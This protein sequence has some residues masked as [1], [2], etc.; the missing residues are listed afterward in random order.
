MKTID[1]LQSGK[2]LLDLFEEFNIKAAL[3]AELPLAILN[4]GI[5]SPKDN[6]IARECR[7]LVIDI[8]TNELVA[9]GFNRF[10]NYGELREETDLFDFSDFHITE[11]ID[12]S[13]CLIYFFQD[14]W[15]ANTRNSFAHGKLQD[16]NLT[17]EE[18]FCRALGILDLQELDSLLDRSLTYVCEFCSPFNKVVRSYKDFEIYLLTMF[19]GENEVPYYAV[20]E[21]KN[22]F[23]LPSQFF[24][25]DIREIILFL[26]E[27]SK[28]DESFEGVVLCDKNNTRLKVKSPT[29]L[30]LHKLK[31]N[32]NIFHPSCLLPFVLSGD[33]DRL[34][35]YFPEVKERYNE[36]LHKSEDAFGRLK[37]LWEY[38]WKIEN[39]KEFALAIVRKSPFSW[40]LFDVRKRLGGKQT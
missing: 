6:S 21:Y 9:R 8:K 4:Y 38:T 15:Y 36:I 5:K 25:N 40:M 17:W 10:F 31:N 11:K 26:E 13:L 33:T 32:N 22:V 12:G 14:K 27:K 24:F 18:G 1:Y 20:R 39:Q 16:C 19:H 35:C 34:F 7:G 29:Y 23:L 3:H 30:S 2:T 28:E 37:S